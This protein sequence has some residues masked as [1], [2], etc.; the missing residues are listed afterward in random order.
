MTSCYRDSER[1]QPAVHAAGAFG[2]QERWIDRGHPALGTDRQ[3]RSTGDNVSF[4]GLADLLG[5]LEVD[6]S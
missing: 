3:R 5:E 6:I 4:G 1:S 2:W